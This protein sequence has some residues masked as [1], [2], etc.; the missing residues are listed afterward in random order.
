MSI[1]EAPITYEE[2]KDKLIG[3]RCTVDYG[4]ITL[5]PDPV[6]QMDK[7]EFK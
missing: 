3:R 4:L 1:I 5:I 7:L 2:L 6:E